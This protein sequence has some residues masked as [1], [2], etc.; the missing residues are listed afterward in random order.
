MDKYT[1]IDNKI[2]LNTVL[3][4]FRDIIQGKQ[5]V[6]G[7]YNVLL[8]SFE[9]TALPTLKT[10]VRLSCTISQSSDELLAEEVPVE[11]SWESGCII[12]Q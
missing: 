2:Y 10:R 11:L 4:F 6:V 3:F 7:K 12:K 8:S 1:C 5:Y 9:N